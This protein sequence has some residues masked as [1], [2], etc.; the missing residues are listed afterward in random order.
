MPSSR[1]SSGKA[2]SRSR[3]R[4]RHPR[5]EAQHR[6][7]IAAAIELIQ[8]KLDLL[9][10]PDRISIIAELSR[11]L[12]ARLQTEAAKLRESFSPAEPDK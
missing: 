8:G 10:Q 1:P 6:A 7:L 3:N 12:A 11:R 2:A 4:K 9:P 5:T